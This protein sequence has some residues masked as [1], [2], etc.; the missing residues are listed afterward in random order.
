MEKYNIISDFFGKIEEI[1][2]KS[3]NQGLQTEQF[4]VEFCCQP[5]LL[6]NRKLI[7]KLLSEAIV[8][9]IASMSII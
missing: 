2:K 9:S 4:I 7:N 1:I 8:P 3:D 5:L 6:K